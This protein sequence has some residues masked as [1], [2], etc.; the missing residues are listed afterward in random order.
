MGDARLAVFVVGNA[1]SG[2]LL[3]EPSFLPTISDGSAM[4]TKFVKFVNKSAER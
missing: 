3:S 2:G 4:I 1:K